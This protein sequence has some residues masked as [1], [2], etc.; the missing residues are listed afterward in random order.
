MNKDKNSIKNGGWPE[1]LKEYN[2][3]FQEKIVNSE[4]LKSHRRR[5]VESLES[6]DQPSHRTD[7]YLR[8]PKHDKTRAL[9]LDGG[10]SSLV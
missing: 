3:K 9:P 8:T 5:L 4:I 1:I 7:T 6:P 10:S 2:Q